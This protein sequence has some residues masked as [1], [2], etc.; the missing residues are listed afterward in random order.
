[1][2]A[3]QVASGAIRVLTTHGYL[4]VGRGVLGRLVGP[5][6]VFV[7]MLVRMVAQV[8][9]LGT[10]L[11]LAIA[12]GRTP[13]EL[14]G[15]H[16]KQADEKKAPHS[17]DFISQDLVGAAVGAERRLTTSATKT[18]SNTVNC[19]NSVCHVG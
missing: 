18:T 14:E 1:M 15:Q 3:A 11:M 7:L 16:H 13:D 10:L 2:A 19:A 17:I 5:V 9:A 8:A 12:C 6:L 4:L